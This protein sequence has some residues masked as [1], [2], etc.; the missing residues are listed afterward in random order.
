[1]SS[2]FLNIAILGPFSHSLVGHSK[3]QNLAA[4]TQKKCFD[5]SVLLNGISKC[6]CLEYDWSEILAIC[7]LPG[8]DKQRKNQKDESRFEIHYF[9]SLVSEIRKHEMAFLIKIINLSL[10]TL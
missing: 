5:S 8:F 3:S 6:F 1:M 10:E 7:V 9:M 2:L 4:R